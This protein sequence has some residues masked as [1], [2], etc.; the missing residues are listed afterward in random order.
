MKWI[1][2]IWLLGQD[3]SGSIGLFND[4]AACLAALSEWTEASSTHRGMCIQGN[5]HNEKH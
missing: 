2:I 3:G 1:L 4:E 5:V